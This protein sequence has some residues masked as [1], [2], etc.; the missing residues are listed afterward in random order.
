[1]YANWVLLGGSVRTLV[2][3]CWGL[4][5]KRMLPHLHLEAGF[6]GKLRLRYQQPLRHR[7]IDVAGLRCLG[8]SSMKS[9]E[10]QRS[11]VVGRWSWYSREGI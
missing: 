5:C 11:P 8:P 9:V 4:L 3:R 10:L 2:T 1:M 7:K 6:V